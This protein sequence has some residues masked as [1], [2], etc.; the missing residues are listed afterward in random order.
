MPPGPGEPQC[1]HTNLDSVRSADFACG[2]SPVIPSWSALSVQVADGL[3]NLPLLQLF[4]R[5]QQ[6]I[7]LSPILFRYR[8]RD[9]RTL[10]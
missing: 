2:S 6:S 9:E 8:G 10:I 3:A 1:S 7:S 5:R 4:P